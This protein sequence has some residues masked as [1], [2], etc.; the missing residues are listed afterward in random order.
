[1][2]GKIMIK[3]FK[4][5]IPTRQVQQKR[6]PKG[7]LY[8]LVTIPNTTKEVYIPHEWLKLSSNGKVYK[9]FIELDR[10]IIGRQRNSITVKGK[11][12]EGIWPSKDGGD[13]D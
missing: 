9:G 10:E 4:V 1:M 5:V 7:N 3:T 6:N 12:L 13:L 11:E 8:Y 2:K